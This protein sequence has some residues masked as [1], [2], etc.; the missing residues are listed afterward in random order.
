MNKF[1]KTMVGNWLNLLKNY[2]FKITY[3]KIMNEICEN[4]DKKLA[5]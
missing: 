4:R 5:Q 2:R 1:V 3:S